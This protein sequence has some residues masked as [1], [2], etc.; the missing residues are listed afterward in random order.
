[1]APAGGVLIGADT[2]E[3]L[4][5]GAVVEERSGLRIKGKDDKVHAYLLLALP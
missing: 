3:Q 4:P 1:L 2:Y 5:E